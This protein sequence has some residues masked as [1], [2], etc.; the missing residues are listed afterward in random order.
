MANPTVK[1]ATG[2]DEAIVNFGARFL[3]RL[4]RWIYRMTGGNKK[5]RLLGRGKADALLLTTVGRKSGQKRTTPLL[6]LKDGDTIV[7]AASKAGMPHHPLWYLNITAN[8]EV[9]VEVGREKIA[10]VARQANA[11]E[12]SRLWPRLVEIYP[13]YAEYQLL[14]DREI[15]VIILTRRPASR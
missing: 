1:K 2:R 14:T 13:A 12:K 11:A 15:P 10:M 6:Y 9:D 7:L 4:D 5:F 3:G 8:P